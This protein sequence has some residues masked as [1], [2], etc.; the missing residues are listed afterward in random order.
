MRFCS[1]PEKTKRLEINSQGVPFIETGYIVIIP[2]R[3]TTDV[4]SV[5]FYE[6]RDAQGQLIE[7]V[8]VTSQVPVSSSHLFPVEVSADRDTAFLT[9]YDY[10][11]GGEGDSASLHP[12]SRQHTSCP[13][14]PGRKSAKLTALAIVNALRRWRGFIF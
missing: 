12:G 14:F 6:Y 3:S 9:T 2:E 13:D 4:R 10:T 11:S 1:V 7:S 5:L 8:P